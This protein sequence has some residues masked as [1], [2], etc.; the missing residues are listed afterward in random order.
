MS[1]LLIA[2]AVAWTAADAPKIQVL[3]GAIPE[4]L[5]P[6]ASCYRATPT[7]VS[8]QSQAVQRL[9]EMP[10]ANEYKLVMRSGPECM[11]P[12]D[13]RFNVEEQRRGV[14][15]AGAQPSRR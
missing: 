10:A 5:R 2:A 9:G 6:Y 4:S 15:P 3:R 7:P 12:S 14:R 13:V 1:L 8:G 11:R